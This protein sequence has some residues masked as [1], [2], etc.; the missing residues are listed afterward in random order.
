MKLNSTLIGVLSL[1]MT[2]STLSSCSSEPKQQ[3]EVA[4]K[5]STAGQATGSCAPAGIEWKVPTGW[6]LGPEKAMRVA[7]YMAGGLDAPAECAVFFFG[8][9]QG[10]DVDGNIA[11]WISQ[12]KQPDGSDSG[13]KAKKDKVKSACCEITTIEVEGTYLASSGPMMQTT[14]EKP[15]F[16]L[17][18]AIASGPKGNVFFKLTGPKSTVDRVRENFLTMLRSVNKMT[19]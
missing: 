10:G 16:V 8:T 15:G 4:G 11:R 3:A 7:T 14:A 19:D 2:I 13:E 5:A 12:V 18:G 6:V 9:G 1:A 17:L